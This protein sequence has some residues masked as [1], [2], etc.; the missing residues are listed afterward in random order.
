MLITAKSES[1]RKQNMYEKLINKA[2]ECHEKAMSATSPDVVVFFLN[3]E[4]EFI[5]RAK[6]LKI[7]EV[8]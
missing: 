5:V 2:N 3:A 6:N 1:S 4:K 8:V 7:S